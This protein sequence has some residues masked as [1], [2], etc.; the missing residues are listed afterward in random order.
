M[1]TSQ[2]GF[3]PYD[4]I[5]HLTSK[6]KGYIEQTLNQN[7]V[8]VTYTSPN[9]AQPLRR[10]EHHADLRIDTGTSQALLRTMLTNRLKQL[11]TLIP[12]LTAIEPVLSQPEQKCA[13]RDLLKATHALQHALDPPTHTTDHSR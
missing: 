11:E 3:L 5:V 8:L 1:P 2:N 12:R 7:D 4:R 6:R 9:P 13:V 10:L